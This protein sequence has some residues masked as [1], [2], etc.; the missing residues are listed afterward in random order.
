[1]TRPIRIGLLAEGEA[2]LGASIPYIKPEEGGKVI[3]RTYEGVLHTLIRRELNAAGFS[4]CEFI[5]RHPTIRERSTGQVRRGYSILESKY[6]RQV[7][8][9]WKP[10]E[11]DM[12]VLVVDADD[13]VDDR[14][15]KIET[16]LNIIQEN[17]LDRDQN[18]VYDRSL[19][20]LAICDIEAWLIADTETLF[21][22]FNL[23]ID[24]I[25]NPENITETKGI[26]NDAIDNSDYLI[27]ENSINKRQMKI[28]WAIAEKIDLATLKTQCPQGYGIFAENLITTSKSTET[29]IDRP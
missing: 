28:R 21:K 3:D 14:S 9:V 23:K 5:Q 15:R 11:I 25:E 12:I 18:E 1:M 16:A 29:Y 20:G 19:T 17:H 6:L 8:S 10:N 26:L 27:E 2:E 24:L 22:H 13:I 4:D 7:V